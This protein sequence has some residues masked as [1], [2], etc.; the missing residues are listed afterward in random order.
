MDEILG[1]VRDHD[2]ETRGMMLFEKQHAL[3]DPVEAVGFGSGAIVRAD[4]Q[5][6]LRKA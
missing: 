2:V 5:M 6:D 4:G 1:I 3:V